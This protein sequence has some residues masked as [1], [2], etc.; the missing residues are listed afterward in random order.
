MSG[1]VRS[2]RAGIL[3][4]LLL[5]TSCVA[6]A[7]E[8]ESSATPGEAPV[9]SGPALR[10]APGRVVLRVPVLLDGRG[11]RQTDQVVVI[12][13][14]RIVSVEPQGEGPLPAGA[15]DLE[16]MT[17]LPGLI[18]THVHAGWFFGEDGRLASGVT[19]E[20]R[21]Q[22]AV[23]NA[24]AMMR[25]G[26]TTIQSLG[27]IE[28]R[29]AKRLLAERE[30]MGPRL[31]SSYGFLAASTGGPEELH[32]AV[33][34]YAEAGADVIKIF[35]S[36]SIRTG[37]APSLTREQLDAACSEAA[38]RGLRAV[39]HAHGPESARRASEA[40]CTTIEHG[41]LL[42]RETLEVLAANGTFYDP[43]IHLIFQNYFDNADRYL[44][45]GSYTEEGFEEMR[46]AVPRALE[47]FQTALTVPGLKTVFGTDAVAGAHG[48]NVEELLYRVREG[49]Q[50]A[51]DAI[52]SA[53]SLAAESLGLADHLGVLA[54]GFIADLIAVEGDA[55]VDA[56]ALTRVRRVWV[57]GALVFRRE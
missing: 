38:S 7:D 25:A 40:G 2:G 8:G 12:E 45:L 35:G 28:D 19:E 6:G 17:L 31:L 4:G 37:G 33:R 9:T 47:A 53:T 43:N 13:D 23:V 52:V 30:A 32:E 44:G 14:G 21:A 34:A 48:R 54:P 26:F 11:A 39:V 3:L 18:D 22:Q 57:G 55:S 36:E 24:D 15:V 50:S 56:E 46:S 49:G 42:D 5:L 20:E 27:G 10:L 16:G 29:T 1:R 51:T 41:A